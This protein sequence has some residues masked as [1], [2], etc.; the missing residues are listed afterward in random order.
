MKTLILLFI[1][2][3][4]VHAD[5]FSDAGDWLEGAAAEYTYALEDY[6]TDL[7]K[8]GKHVLLTAH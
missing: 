7:Y 1:L 3:T 8:A 6:G 2:S 4:S 5:F